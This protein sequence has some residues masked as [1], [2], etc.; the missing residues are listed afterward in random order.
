MVPGRGSN[1]KPLSD[2][3]NKLLSGK[4]SVKKQKSSACA[5]IH[6]L[7]WNII[8]DVVYYFSYVLQTSKVSLKHPFREQ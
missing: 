7:L 3:T 2:I 4:C 6:V 8:V 5:Q 1:K